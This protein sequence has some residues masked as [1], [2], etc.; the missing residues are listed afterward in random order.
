MK[1]KHYIDIENLREEDTE[2][3]QS[4][5]KGFEVGDIIS[6][7]EK[8]DGSNL[9]ICYDS[10]T[11]SLKAFSRKQELTYNNTLSG[12]WNLINVLDIKAF[13]TH[14]TWRIFGEW[15]GNRNKILYDE[16]FKN[17]WIIFDIYDIESEQ[18]LS[19]DIVKDFC[20]EADLEYIHELYHGEFISWEH[21]RSFLHSPN[22]G[23]RQEGVVVKNQS[24]LSSEDNRLP[25]YLKIVNDDFKESM[26]H[27][28]RVI[29]PEKEQ[30]KA[31]AMKIVESI[32]TRNRVEKEL[33]KMRD[34]G[35][36]PE[37]L[38]PKDMS[39]VAKNLPKRVYDDCVKE[40]KEL[41]IQCGEY[42]GKMCGQQTM[43][44][45]KEIVLGG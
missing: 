22:Y 30:A 17:K 2:L 27:H 3:R 9:C 14:P 25:S 18:W 36:I 37:K 7:T 13:K 16:R 44:F 6:I 32:V 31:E 12:A 11:D 21:V 42:F 38:Q 24:K 29:D 15:S 26:K 1:Q 23:E 10:E 40:E 5:A 4:N 41:V 19:Q 33:F 34:E 8:I 20:K 45:A 35:I 43:K 28:E 39:I